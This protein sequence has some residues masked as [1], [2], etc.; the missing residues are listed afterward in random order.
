MGRAPSLL[1]LVLV[2]ALGLAGS[3][4]LR[5]AGEAGGQ[6]S[7]I[8]AAER[9]ELPGR[10]AIRIV[11]RNPAGR[12]TVLLVHGYGASS[13]SFKPVVAEL[14]LDRRVI[15]VDLPGF[16]ASDR[17]EGDYSPDALADEL[18][19]VLDARH[20]PRAH[21]IGHSWGA[22]VALAFALR[23]PDRLG[24]LVV[25]S[26]W[27]F[28]DQLLPLMRWAAVPGL[29]ELLFATFFPQALGERI[30]FNFHDPGLVTEKVVD[31]IR[32]K[33]DRAGS[34]AVALAAA[35]G[36]VKSFP[37]NEKRYREIGAD[38]LLLWGAD[39]RVARVGFGERLARQLPHAQL[40]VLPACGHIPMWECT[41]GVSEAL[42]V[43][44]GP[45]PLPLAAG[46]SPR[47]QL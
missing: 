44:F 46:T 24:R 6:G 15:A 38:T 37:E 32:D 22:S 4:C 23:H 9:L 40:V 41:A 1:V 20:I 17:L 16:G 29:G 14:A 10:G 25:I 39:D 47:E 11:D 34:T 2:L 28:D 43:F 19:R 21:V 30:Y 33:A 13:A 3:G 12:E 8:V 31:D 5:F 26:G 27:V 36:M 7:A 35:R 45:A 42:R 18:V